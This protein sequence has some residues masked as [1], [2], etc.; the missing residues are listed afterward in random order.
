VARF[1]VGVFL[2]AMLT[3]CPVYIAEVSTCHGNPCTYE[4]PSHNL[5]L[6]YDARLPAPPPGANVWA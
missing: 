1:A 4:L 5:Y 2:G 3:V 6:C